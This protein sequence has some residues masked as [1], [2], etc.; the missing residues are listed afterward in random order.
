LNYRPD[1][2]VLRA[3]AVLSVVFFHLDIPGFQGGFVGVD[4]FFVISGYLITSIIKDKYENHKFKL[5]DF[6]VRRIRRLVPP[7]IATTAATLI[8]ASFVMLPYNMMEFARSATAALFS[9]SNIV[10]YMESGYW[11][12]A[13]ELKPL[14]HTWSLGVE[15]QFY[16]FWPA[17][18]VG[19]LTIR[20]I[21]S[22]AI[23]GFS[24]FRWGM[25]FAVDIKHQGQCEELPNLV[26][27]T[28]PLVRNFL[29]NR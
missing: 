18:I 12:S 16:L 14:L 25:A 17:L 29:H 26:A 28:Y 10:F 19:L 27:C 20:R 6:Y 24:V 15:E 21:L 8:A 1:I 7:L 22:L 5:S 4:I 11:D 3:I 2:D 23:Q 13:S 9:L